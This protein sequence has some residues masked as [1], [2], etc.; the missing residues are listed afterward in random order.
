MHCLTLGSPDRGSVGRCSH[1]RTVRPLI[2]LLEDRT[3]LSV[4]FAPDPVNI[5]KQVVEFREAVAGTN[6]V[7]QWSVTGAGQLAYQWNGG[8]T[9]TDLDSLAPGVQ[10]LPLSAISQVK[11]LLGGGDDRLILNAAG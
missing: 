3:L 4:A 6:D 1:P 11:A 5:G 8:P 10:A 7:L 9:T 2:E